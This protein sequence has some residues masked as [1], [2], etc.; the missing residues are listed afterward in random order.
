[1]RKYQP[2]FTKS[3]LDKAQ[4]DPGAPSQRYSDGELQEFRELIQRKLE[5]AKKELSYLHG[6]ITRK[7]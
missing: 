4:R 7:G 2:D 6:L 5:A 1:V 3:V